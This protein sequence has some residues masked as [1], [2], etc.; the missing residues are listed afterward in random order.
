MIIDVAL[1]D[2]VVF[3]GNDFHDIAVLIFPFDLFDL[4]VK[5]PQTAGRDRSSFISF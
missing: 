1:A 2:V 4:V 5:D 3:I